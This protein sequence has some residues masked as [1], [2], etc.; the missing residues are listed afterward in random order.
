MCP[1]LEN[2][3]GSANKLHKIGTKEEYSL[4]FRPLNISQMADTICGHVSLKTLQTECNV[5]LSDFEM[6]LNIRRTGFQ[7]PFK[8]DNSIFSMNKKIISVTA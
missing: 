1:T 5:A 7:K 8:S 6:Q 2:N 3:R 4:S